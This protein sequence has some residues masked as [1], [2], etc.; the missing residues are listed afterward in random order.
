MSSTRVG[1][2]LLSGWFAVLLFAGAVPAREGHE[3]FIYGEVALVNG[4][5]YRGVI[6]WSAGQRLWVDLL[7]AEKQDN[8]V[9]RYLSSEQL[10]KLS[11]EETEK[12]T[13]WG[14]L[15]LWK[16]KYPAR[17]HTLRCRFG[18]LAAVRVTDDEEAVVTLKNGDQLKVRGDD[19]GEY[20]NQVG[21]AITVYPDQ[22]GKKE[23]DWDQIA[24]IRFIETPPVLPGWNRRPLYGTVSTPGGDHT[25]FITWDLDEDLVSDQLDGK[26]GQ[27]DKRKIPFADIVSLHPQGEG[28]LVKRKDGQEVYLEDNSDV[29]RTNRGI[30]VKHPDRGTV[31]IRWK[32]LKGVAFRPPDIDAG[33]GRFPAAKRLRGVVHTTNGQQVRGRL[34]FDL[35]EQWNCEPIDGQ[36]GNGLTHQIP[37]RS[38]QSVTP[39][40][41]RYTAVRLRDGR[42]LVL[43]GQHDVSEKNWG[44][45]VWRGKDKYRYIPWNQV[46]T[47]TLE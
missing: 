11:E 45:M 33:Y 38:I 7:V 32:D 41:H 10:E 12:Q 40:N 2:R 47:L 46:S 15:N 6:R 39:R 36:E 22:Q 8:P 18:D 21:Q 34:T 16:N 25:G 27:D 44:V 35:D 30:L 37:F 20:A 3:A 31:T 23:I 19:E 1:F 43:G 29:S 14:F 42:T 17:K 26:T 9:L 4:Q 28:A 24:S 5:R 13:D